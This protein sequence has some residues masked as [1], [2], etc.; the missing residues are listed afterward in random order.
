MSRII[1]G[2]KIESSKVLRA[3]ELRRQMTS[4]EQI[5]WQAL[6]A[7]RLQGW[8]FR[9]QQVIDGFIVDFYCHAARL[10]IEVD[11]DIHKQQAVYDKDRDK[12]LAA[13]GVRVLRFQ[14]SDILQNL[15]H[16]L[17]QITQACRASLS[18]PSLGEGLGERSG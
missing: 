1:T 9:R 17:T 18:P 15:E 13:Q 3:R 12:I 6:R 16:V 10:V 5:L 11:G 2:Q 8:H 14:N 4:A 7:N